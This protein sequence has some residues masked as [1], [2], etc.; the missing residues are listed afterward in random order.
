MKVRLAGWAALGLFLAVFL[1]VYTPVLHTDYA[2]SDDYPDLAAGPQGGSIPKK[3]RE[4]R[5]LYA[6]ATWLFLQSATTIEELRYARF[7]GVVGIGLMAW[8]VFLILVR[9]G[10]SRFQSFC[11][12]V[13]IG[14]SLPFQ[15]YAAWATAATFPFASTVS[16]LAFLLAEWALATSR[17]LR[18]GLLAA[19][20]SLVL[21]AALTIY[22]PAA[23]FFWVCVAIVVLKPDTP[24]GAMIRRLRF[25]GL[26]GMAGLPLAF[27]VYELG[28]VVYPD[29]PA[30]TGLVQDIPAKVVWFLGEVLPNALNFVLLSP[31]YLLL[32]GQGSVPLHQSVDVSIAQA[33]AG[34]IYYYSSFI[35]IRSVDVGIAWAVA[36]L[37]A[38]GLL[39]YFQGTW[40]E[41]LWKLGL[42]GMLLPLSYAPNLVAAESWASYRSL[43]SL[44]SLVVVYTF[45]AWRGYASRCRQARRL[46]FS[47]VWA[48]AAAGGLASACALLA[49][50]HVQTSFVVP[51]VREL[52]FMRS[53]LTQ[54]NLAEARSIY[55]IRARWQDTL[56]PPVRYDEFGLPSSFPDWGALG[57]VSLLLREL[58]PDSAHLP[59]ISVAADGRI[60]PPPDSLVV[61][62]RRM[63]M[64]R[65]LSRLSPAAAGS[66]TGAG[67][68]GA[69]Q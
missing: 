28:A 2:F 33:V 29:H 58:A 5:P 24:P 32:S 10:W 11:V 39:L 8:L 47:P 18:Q 59:V 57:M 62:M 50:W 42:A 16:G 26:I 30:R 61:D 31:G 9:A 67:P 53:Q 14:T 15:V 27:G 48:N 13:M 22:Q 60:T 12:G 69:G 38:G 1:T 7:G 64:R 45:L 4:G 44:S 23:M 63:T 36:G 20:S 54:G 3:I 49:T 56:A 25:Y 40:R 43:S 17:R 41:R 52:E 51:Q 6:L 21:L 68:S 65:E 34:L 66:A 19:G 35:L 37:T 46:T 55:V